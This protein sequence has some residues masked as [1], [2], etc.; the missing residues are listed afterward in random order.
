MLQ[1]LKHVS[2]L[3]SGSMSGGKVVYPAGWIVIIHRYLAEKRQRCFTYR[4]F[5]VWLYRHDEY[6]DLEWHTVERTLRRLAKD[7]FLDRR[8]RGRTVLFC[9]NERFDQVLANLMEG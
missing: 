4:G 1:R 2:G 7:Q 5:R 6:R 8:S 9:R 3:G